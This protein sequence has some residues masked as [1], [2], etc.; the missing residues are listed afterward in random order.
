MAVKNKS[1]IVRSKRMGH[2]KA[3]GHTIPVAVDLPTGEP[4]R[5][6][7]RADGRPSVVA[8]V[9]GRVSATRKMIKRA[10]E[11]IEL[12]R[13]RMAN[14]QIEIDR[15]RIETRQMIAELLT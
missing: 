6:V 7:M 14:D 5:I 10:L 9:Q 8:T 13:R 15:L 3:A 4:V 11:N 12:A 1:G 2:Q